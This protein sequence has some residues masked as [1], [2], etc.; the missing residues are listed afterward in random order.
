MNRVTQMIIGLVA[1]LLAIGAG[2]YGRNVYLKDVSTYQVPVPVTTIPP[3]TILSGNQF[4]M[5][6]M[7][8]SMESLP[9]NHTI[10]SMVGKISEVPLSAGLPVPQASISPVADFRLADPAYEV[11][12][13]PV[14]PV[15]AVGGQVRI[16]EHINLY[17]VTPSTGIPQ[18]SD[19]TGVTDPV[20]INLIAG[21]VLVVDV[22]SAQGAAAAVGRPTTNSGPFGSV[23]QVEQVQILT[24]AVEPGQVKTI[25]DAVANAKKQGGLLWTSLAL[26]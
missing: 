13:I 20:Q 17:Q 12:S 9:Y 5:V 7:P 3:Y 18:A 24:L 14:D 11:L 19:T 8:R 22:R 21:K 2:I 6:D 4:Q 23:Q 26:P 16:G 15:S 25:L 1:V 10:D